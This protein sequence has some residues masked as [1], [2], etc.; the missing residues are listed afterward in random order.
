IASYT[1]ISP[2]SSFAV[3]GRHSFTAE[4]PSA[5]AARSSL[6]MSA[7]IAPAPPRSGRGGKRS[8]ARPRLAACR[9]AAG[10][11]LPCALLHHPAG[12]IL[13]LWREEARSHAPHPP[14]LS[15]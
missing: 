9:S 8:V 11:G 12:G 13:E 6:D 14:P 4:A 3:S 1:T 15:R 7:S 2:L 10:L 5:E